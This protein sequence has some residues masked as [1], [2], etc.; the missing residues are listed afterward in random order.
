[1][2]IKTTFELVYGKDKTV[3]SSNRKVN[4]WGSVHLAATDVIWLV[5]AACHR[6]YKLIGCRC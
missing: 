6:Y 3:F 4:R 2:G 5:Y 1:M